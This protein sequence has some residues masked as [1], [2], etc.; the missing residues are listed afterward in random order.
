MSKKHD[1]KARREPTVDSL[2]LALPRLPDPVRPTPVVRVTPSSVNLREIEDRRLWHPN[3]VRPVVSLDNA[4]HRLLAPAPKK[5][6]VVRNEPR[7]SR[8]R[9]VL[10]QAPVALLGPEI[11]SFNRRPTAFAEAKRMLVCIRRGMR[12]EVLHALR[13]TG[14]GG[15]RKKQRPRY[16]SFSNVRCR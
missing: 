16:N 13:K 8:S 7:K 3:P 6:S 10:Y 9:S 2:T 1:R 15:G 14:K 12:K 4:V 5:R 11:G